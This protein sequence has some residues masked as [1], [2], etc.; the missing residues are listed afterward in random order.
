MTAHE[1]LPER[2][3]VPNRPV[4]TRRCRRV[5][6]GGRAGLLIAVL[7]MLLGACA[8]PTAPPA[9]TAAPTAASITPGAPLSAGHSVRAVTVD[10]A[11]RTF[12][13]YRPE[14]L[15]EPA[16]LVLVFHG[17]GGEA[18]QMVSATGWP[19][20]ADEG[21]AVVVF[22][23]GVGRSFN[24]GGCCGEADGNAVDDVAAALA[25]I[26][27][28]SAAA[29]IDADRVYSTGFSNGGYMSYRLACETDR[30]AAIAPVAGSRL[31]P[32]ES[33]EPTSLLHIH[34]LA[35][36]RVPAQG[37]TRDGVVIPPVEDVVSDWRQALDCGP[38]T[39]STGADGELRR[40]ST[41]CPDGRAVDLV[42]LESFAHSW[43]QA[44]DGLDATTA[45]WDFFSQHR[46]G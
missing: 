6:R 18:A 46:R 30:F 21:G 15:A 24:G 20:V 34:G 40:T 13:V 43:P 29:S 42:T 11:E 17:F 41:T 33:P 9:P 5:A 27:D 14:R 36:Q 12:R 7:V 2:R 22:P 37:E 26:D 16:P 28:V 10:G 4:E 19:D 45:A 8:T 25:M 1:S 3:L 39:E 38:A 31:V 23:E 35:D 32:C 44:T